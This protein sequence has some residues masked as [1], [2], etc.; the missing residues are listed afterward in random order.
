MTITDIVAK[1][2]AQ[3]TE[4]GIPATINQACAVVVVDETQAN[5]TYVK[6][7]LQANYLE[8][9]DLAEGGNQPNLN[10][11]KVK[12]FPLSLPGLPEQTEIVRRVEARYAAARQTRRQDF[13]TE[14]A[15]SDIKRFPLAKPFIRMAYEGRG[16]HR[17]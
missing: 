9:R 16:Q 14:V 12:E 2:R 6:L 13:L 17:G 7:V 1:T 4:L 15:M 11:S 8:M 10:L 3:V 5:R